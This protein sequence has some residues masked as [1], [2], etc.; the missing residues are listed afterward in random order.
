MT[1]QNCSCNKLG[2]SVII[3]VDAAGT[4]TKYAVIGRDK[5][6]LYSCVG[7]S[8]SPAVNPNAVNDIYH[9]LEEIYNIIENVHQLKAI[10]LGISGFALVD[11]EDFTTRLKNRFNTNIIMESDAYMAL[12]S[13]L[14]DKYENGIVV[15]SGTGAVILALNKG[16][17]FMSNGWG[18]LL[19]ER[20]SAYTSVRDFVCKMIH[21]NEQ[22]GYLSPLEQKFLKYMN[23]TKLEDFKMLFY[24]HHKDEIAVYSKFFIEEAAKGDEEAIDWLYHNGNLL[25]IDAISA[26]KRVS[27]DGEFAIGFRGG[28]ISNASLVIQGIMEILNNAGYKP[29][30][31]EGE[32]NPIFGGY[33]LAKRLGFL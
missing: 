25:G 30:V 29:R 3:S 4:S 13:I 10:I 23:Y 7:V 2:S 22:K 33:F 6:V 32:N 8:G 20:G 18:E 1:L 27:M 17:L 28:F 14:Q 9:K 19:T 11:V 15:V 12:F 21:N 5:E 26:S 16:Q 24:R 31:V